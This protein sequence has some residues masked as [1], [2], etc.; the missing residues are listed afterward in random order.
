MGIVDFRKLLLEVSRD[1][2]VK[3]MYWEC[4]EGR[5]QYTTTSF[6]PPPFSS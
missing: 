1:K 5:R 4:D 6:C 2:N 3:F